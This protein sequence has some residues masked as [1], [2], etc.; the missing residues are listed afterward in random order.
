MKRWCLSISIFLMLG[1]LASVVVAYGCWGWANTPIAIAKTRS[2]STDWNAIDLEGDTYR[3][4]LWQRFAQEDWLLQPEYGTG[5]RLPTRSIEWFLARRYEPRDP[6]VEESKDSPVIETGDPVVAET[7]EEPVD[8]ETAQ[9]ISVQGDIQHTYI[10]THYRFGWPVYCISSSYADYTRNSDTLYV[11]QDGIEIGGSFIYVLP[12][13]LIVRGIV[14]NSLF[15]ACLIAVGYYGLPW[16]RC[17]R[18]IKR[19]FC[20]ACKYDLRHNLDAGCPECG[21]GRHP[22]NSQTISDESA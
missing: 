18:R 10:V 15:Y 14:T 12:E 13:V 20:P 2:V 3:G 11:Y 16:Y 22:Q 5:V 4:E 21:W 1:L 8:A 9:W 7:D 19:G 17:N 6:V